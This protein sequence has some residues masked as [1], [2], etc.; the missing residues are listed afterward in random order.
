[1]PQKVQV[2]TNKYGEAITKLIWV[3][4]S[5]LHAC[6]INNKQI[7]KTLWEWGKY[8]FIHLRLNQGM[9]FREIAD[10]CN[11]H[12]L[13]I[14]RKSKYVRHNTLSIQAKNPLMYGTNIY[15]KTTYIAPNNKQLE[16]G[17]VHIKNKSEWVIENNAVP[18]LITEEQYNQLQTISNKKA[19]K[20]G[21]TSANT[22]NDKLLVNIPDKFYCANCGSKII[23]SGKHYVCSKYNSYGK[24]GCGASSFYV[25]SEWLDSK[26]EKEIIKL[27][28]NEKT[29]QALYDQY[30]NKYG[31]KVD[32][33]DNKVDISDLQK[34]LK[35]KKQEEANLLNIIASGN[36]I[37]AALNAI[38][39]K[40]NAVSEEVKTLEAQIDKNNKPSRYKILTYDYFKQL[41][42]EGSKLLTH[43]S[44]AEKRAFIEKCIE[45]VTLD[46]VRKS[47]NVK[48]NIN[49]FWTSLEK[50]KKTKKLEASKLETSSE[51]VAGAGFEPTTFGL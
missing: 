19:R 20:T 47:V 12:K 1:M 35:K 23:S 17:H 9:S 39:T 51:M 26:L 50:P 4:N 31:K 34:A 30:I 27:I 11:M 7:T 10:F 22:T 6:T 44:L 13:P 45:S 18:A 48:F 33:E 3:E 8:I 42:H 28:L 21:N 16:K 43:S 5:S 15:N 37:G 2:G 40:L 29:I 25:N 36:V 14:T 49:P 41:C 24:K 38:T 32:M 46:P